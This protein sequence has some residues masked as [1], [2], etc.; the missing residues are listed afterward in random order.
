MSR[1]YRATRRR[2]GRVVAVKSVALASEDLA[3]AERRGAELQKQFHADRAARARRLRRPRRGPAAP[4]RDGVHRRRGPLDGHSHARPARR[5]RRGSHRRRPRRRARSARTSSPPRST[6]RPTAASSTAISSR[7]TCGSRGRADRFDRR[8]KV[9]DFGVAKGIR[10]GGDGET[11][12]VFGSAPYMAPER[13]IDGA[14]SP[15]TDC[16]SLGVVLCEMLTGARAVLGQRARRVAADRARLPALPPDCPADLARSSSACWRGSRRR[17]TPRR[18]RFATSCRA[19]SMPP[20]KTAP[21]PTA[22]WIAP[23]ASAALAVP[24]PDTDEAPSASTARRSGATRRTS[25]SHADCGVRTL[26]DAPRSRCRRSRPPIRPATAHRR[27]PARRR[28]RPR[29]GCREWAALPHP[30]ARGRGHGNRAKRAAIASAGAP[31]AERGDVDDVERRPRGPRVERVGAARS[32]RAR[33]RARCA[34][35]HVE[36]YGSLN[37]RELVRRRH[38]AGARTAPARARPARRSRARRFPPA[39]AD[40]ARE[41]VEAGAQLGGVGARAR[42][43]L[44]RFARAS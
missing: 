40:G 24:P 13:L 29:R 39:R 1:V 44:R 10:G 2:D 11:R 43:R 15:A 38:V 19:G 41:P 31:G 8:L 35:R 5:R 20:R 34:R 30:P 27:R 6:A 23:A 21:A 16:W 37:E 25:G 42:R 14:V 12:N 36:T 17:A 26:R 28:H 9:L 22:A 33:G 18:A 7:G 4:D 3:R 32:P